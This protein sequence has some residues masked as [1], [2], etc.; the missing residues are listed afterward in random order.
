MA[1]RKKYPRLP[2]GYGSIKYL[3]KNRTNSYAVYPPVTDYR[4]NGSAITPKALCYVNDW[5]KGF[6]I[7][8]LYKNGQ[9]VPGQEPPEMLTSESPD[10]VLQ[11]IINDYNEA[12]RTKANI[13]KD[14]TFKEVYDAFYDFKYNQDKSR[15]YSKESMKSTKTAFNNCKNLHERIFKDL[16]HDDLQQ[17]VDNCELKHASLELIVS[18][19]H[20]MYAYADI[21]GLV[22][23]DQSAHVKIKKEDDDEHGVPFTDDEL[24]ILWKNKD[25]EIVRFILIMCY[26]GYRIAAYKNLEVNLKEKYFF[27]GIKTRTSKNRI[28]PIHSAILPL[29]KINIKH[30]GLILITEN[31]F[32]QRMYETLSA[33]GIQKHTPHDCR[34]TFSRLCEKYEVN[35]NDRKRMLGHS[36]GKDITNSIYGHRSLDDLRKEIQKIEIC[37]D[38]VANESIKSVSKSQELITN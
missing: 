11:H 6:G 34:H 24:K 22:D 29:V 1:K 28:V 3:G 38:R 14:K 36:F 12:K 20:Q 21:Y 4:D 13:T 18:L 23:K 16:K 15:T 37:C 33:L 25:D 5:M 9:Y 17:V 26:S 2:N 35:D 32:R 10:D 27:G 30:G 7:L 8:T 31:H 19:F